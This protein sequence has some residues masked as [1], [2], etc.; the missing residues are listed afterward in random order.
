MKKTIL[1]TLL[2]CLLLTAVP[3][4]AFATDTTAPETVIREPGQ[5]GDDMTWSYS[6]GTLTISGTGAMD[7]YPDGD[8]P[9]LDKKDEITRVVFTGGVTSVGEGAFRDYDNLTD[10]SFGSAMHTIGP[11]AFQSCDGLTELYLPDTFRKFGK[12]C[13]RNCGN[14]TAIRCRGGMPRFEDSCLWDLYATVYYPTNNPW[15]SEPLMQL[16]QAFQGRIQFFMAGPDDLIPVENEPQTAP[17][18]AQTPTEPAVT[19]PEETVP[20]TTVRSDIPVVSMTEP[21]E[22]TEA[23]TEP[24][25]EA[26]TEAPTE[27]TP[28]ETVEETVPEAI[29]EEE[30]KGLNINGVLVGICLITGT[31]S[32]ILLGALIFHRRPY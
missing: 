25:T 6:G 1:L 20:P 16:F 31:L 28:P 13:F 15:P 12:E 19:A 32:L 7:D 3:M 30:K 4:E 23:A 24:S 21:A 9:W 18:P 22:T 8:A 29:P 27:Q 26:P 17:Q 2:L 11:H 14:L 10:V 5:C